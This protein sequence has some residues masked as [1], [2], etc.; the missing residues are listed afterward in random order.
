MTARLPIS[1]LLAAL[2]VACDGTSVRDVC[3]NL[4]AQKA[5][6]E[7]FSFD[8]CIDDA[9]FLQ[10]DARSHGC[11]EELDD[12]LACVNVTICTADTECVVER[13]TLDACVGGFP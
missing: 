9:N 5:C 4:D 13:D 2:A 1:I 12:Y 10:D 11:D 3:E 7:D 6:F 8:D